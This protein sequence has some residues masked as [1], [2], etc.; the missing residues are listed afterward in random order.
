LP[1]CPDTHGGKAAIEPR[2]HRSGVDSTEYR[3]LVG[4]IR[5]LLHTRPDLA[6]AFGFP[7][8]FMER[9][10]EEHMKVAKRILRYVNGTL[11]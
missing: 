3:R 6:F 7:S 11:D 4:S 2:Q 5:Y 1:P 10:T 8:G 9:P